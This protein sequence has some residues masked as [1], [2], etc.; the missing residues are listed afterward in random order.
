MIGK[1]EN[2]KLIAIFLSNKTVKDGI[3]D[4]ADD[5][6]KQFLIQGKDSLFYSIR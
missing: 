5:V 2:E 6:L 3:V 4:R 1:I